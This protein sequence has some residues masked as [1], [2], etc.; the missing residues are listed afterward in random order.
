MSETSASNAEAVGKLYDRFAAESRD[1]WPEE[2]EVPNFGFGEHLHF[3][4]WESEDDDAPLGVAALRL[5]DMVI[6]RLRVD[7]THHVLDVGCG[8]GGP[9]LR[10]ARRTGA[11]V[12]GITVSE[13][14]IE[15]AKAVAR[16]EGLRLDFQLA[17]ALRLPFPDASFD[18]VFALESMMHMPDRRQVLG[19][20]A[21]VLR[22]GGRL[23][24]TDFFERAPI[25][26]VHRPFVDLL[27]ESSLITTVPVEDYP[28]MLR[29]AGMLFDEIRDISDHTT[30]K[31]F[32]AMSKP[33]TDW[34][35]NK[36]E[37][38]LDQ[39]L[40]AGIPAPGLIDV[41]ELGYLLL[42]AQRP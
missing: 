1:L 3:G 38:T 37:A 7:D 30:R 20:I 17:D 41:K 24:L 31:T 23:V 22:P 39:A 34:A 12:T 40:A 18:A 5:T 2:A 11:R 26:E 27:L 33:W 28:Q 6:D 42:A 14:Q 16:S 8:I 10:T 21:R 29:D 32:I 4:Y 36:P 35:A 13:A 25:P 15:Q 9:A 19:E